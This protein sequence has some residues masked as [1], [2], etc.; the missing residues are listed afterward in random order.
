MQKYCTRNPQSCSFSSNDIPESCIRIAIDTL[1]NDYNS[2]IVEM[3][4]I[5]TFDLQAY[6]NMTIGP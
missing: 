2:N 5:S 3:D 6:K 4:F 1:F